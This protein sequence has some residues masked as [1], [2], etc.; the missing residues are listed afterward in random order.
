MR[1]CIPLA[2]FGACVLL[3]ATSSTCKNIVQSLADFRLA[4]D[5]SVRIDDFQQF[6]ATAFDT[7]THDSTCIV[8]GTVYFKGDPQGEAVCSLF[9]GTNIVTC[10]SD[11]EGKYA[12][13]CQACFI[14]EYRIKACYD[15]ACNRKADCY[16]TD[17]HFEWNA[18][19]PPVH[20]DLCIG[21][22][23]PCPYPKCD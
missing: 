2:V 12:F 4:G 5:K 10:S 17:H 14:G 7:G 19:L 16:G 18:S 11:S 9:Y 23:G 13:W 8:Y 15:G 1:R 20:M 21:R 22:G 6:K 3:A